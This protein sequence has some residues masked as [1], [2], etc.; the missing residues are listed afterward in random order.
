MVIPVPRYVPPHR[1]RPSGT[2]NHSTVSNVSRRTFTSSSFHGHNEDSNIS[3]ITRN[4]SDICVE[5]YLPQK[6]YYYRVAVLPEVQVAPSIPLILLR[7]LLN[8]VVPHG[9]DRHLLAMASGYINNMLKIQT[10]LSILY[11]FYLFRV[12]IFIEV[13]GRMS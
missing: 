2:P 13:Q 11:I 9:T 8:H 6:K 4:S 7:S 10:W 3:N 12:F 5:V 1:S